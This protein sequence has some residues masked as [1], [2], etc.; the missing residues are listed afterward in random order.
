MK[1]AT[2]DNRRKTM[3]NGVIKTKDVLLN[4]LSVIAVSGIKGYF[5]ILWRAFSRK[6]YRFLDFVE[7]TNT[8]IR[9]NDLR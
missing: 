5:R 7:V 3:I 6:E 9:M 4:P 1:I 2:I 8:K